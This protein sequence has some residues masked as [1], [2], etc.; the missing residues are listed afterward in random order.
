[1][2]PSTK[3]ENYF[4]VFRDIIRA[5]HSS[6][7]LQE[8]LNVVVT[9]SSDVLNAKG[10]LLR[11]FNEETNQFDVRAAGGGPLPAAHLAAA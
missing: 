6:T 1:M 4:Y 7:S 3:F 8:V 5:M 2:T 9:K 11:I 10:A